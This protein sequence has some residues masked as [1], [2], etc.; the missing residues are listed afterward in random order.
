[1]SVHKRENPRK[2]YWWEDSR[3]YLRTVSRV[4]G[5]EGHSVATV[6]RV[7]RSVAPYTM[8]CAQT[9]PPPLQARPALV[10]RPERLT[11][12]SRQDTFSEHYW[13]RRG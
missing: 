13:A 10:T 1:M 7:I 5:E 2:G 6:V 8:S 4:F 3:L 12:K 9:R 11:L